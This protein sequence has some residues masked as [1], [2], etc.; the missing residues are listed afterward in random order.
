VT[1]WIGFA[2]ILLLVGVLL[3]LALYCVFLVL[4][5]YKKRNGLPPPG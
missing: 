2:L 1:T 4:R 5:D 3:G